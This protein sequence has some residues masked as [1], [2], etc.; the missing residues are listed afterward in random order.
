MIFLTRD[1]TRMNLNTETLRYRVY[2]SSVSLFLCIELDKLHVCPLSQECHGR[3]ELHQ[4]VYNKWIF[5]LKNE[6][7]SKINA[8]F[9][10]NIYLFRRD[11]SKP[12]IICC[13]YNLS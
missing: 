10:A 4:N 12:I 8:K 1:F 9:V 2:F 6:K 5:I 11:W 13:K 7:L 3:N